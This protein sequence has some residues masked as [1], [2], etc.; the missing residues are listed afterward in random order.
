[1]IYEMLGWKKRKHS[2]CSAFDRVITTG[3][4]NFHGIASVAAS[5]LSP[6][7]TPHNSIHALR[8]VK[9]HR[10]KF[11]QNIVRSSCF[12]SYPQ[13]LSET[14]I[15]NEWIL[16][17]KGTVPY[18]GDVVLNYWLS[19]TDRMRVNKQKGEVY[20]QIQKCWDISEFLSYLDSYVSH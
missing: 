14:V 19:K 13:L 2:F 10:L 8:K 3:T 17:V 11:K 5:S 16:S 9:K 7:N 6:S 12:F 4:C 20:I 18:R 1:M 15:K